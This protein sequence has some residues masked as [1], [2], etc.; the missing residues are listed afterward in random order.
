MNPSPPVT[1]TTSYGARDADEDDA[2]ARGTRARRRV[3][4]DDGSTES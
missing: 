3:D 4:D 2:P 1:T